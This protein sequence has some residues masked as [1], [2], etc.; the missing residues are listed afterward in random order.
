MQCPDSLDFGFL[1][2]A[3]F[4]QEPEEL[5]DEQSEAEA[6]QGAASGT[7]LDSA[8]VPH[9]RPGSPP[10]SEKPISRQNARRRRKRIAALLLE[11]QLPRARTLKKYVQPATPL[12]TSLATQNL[13]V[14]SCGYHGRPTSPEDARKAYT[15]RDLLPL[16]FELVPWDGL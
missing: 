7:P 3:A 11:G 4:S 14:T 1:L 2:R 5:E 6:H 13:P 12:L 8:P 15:L 9:P 16:G 10:L